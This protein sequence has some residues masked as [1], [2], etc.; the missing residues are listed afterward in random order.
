MPLRQWSRTVAS[1]AAAASAL[2]CAQPGVGIG[3][4]PLHERVTHR[5]A[6]LGIVQ[7]RLGVERG[8]GAAVQHERVQCPRTVGGVVRLGVLKV[9][10]DAVSQTHGDLRT[11]RA[12]H[13]AL[14]EMQHGE[15]GLRPDL[16]RPE[17]ALLEQRT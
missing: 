17:G 4:D 11:C 6:G 8:L 9:P 2:T 3:Q 14:Q 5:T 7:Q 13:A 15:L 10:L 16:D 12:V 1:A